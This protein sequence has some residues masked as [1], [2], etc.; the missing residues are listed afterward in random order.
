MAA[1]KILLVLGAGKNIG[2]S[3]ANGFKAAGYQVALVSRSA[4]DSQI[5]PEGF[6]TIKGDLKNPASILAIFETVKSKLGG[7]P[8]TVVYNAM[9]VSMPTDPT[10]PFTT[11]VESFEGD[12]TV[13]NTSAYIAA[14]EA[15]AGFEAAD[16]SA[17]K[18]FIY[19]GNFLAAVTVPMAQY[20][21]LGVGKS[22]ASYWVGAA[23]SIYKEKGYR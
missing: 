21:T 18:A 15:V 10:N 14:R 19:T 4:V 16:E 11:P 22:A 1:S 9:A 8:T 3:L 5:T 23:S 6:L 7:P 12:F 2:Q 17:P 20:I 13:S